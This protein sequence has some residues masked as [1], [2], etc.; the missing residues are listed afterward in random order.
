MCS[1][2]LVALSQTQ[3]HE[4]VHAMIFA[5][6]NISTEVTIN[7][8]PITWLTTGKMGYVAY[9]S[10]ESANKCNEFCRAQNNMA[11]LVDYNVAALI[12]GCFFFGLII[13]LVILMLNEE[14]RRVIIVHER[15]EQ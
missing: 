1:F 3:A 7:Y 4:S 6:Y 2:Y 5:D 8:N 11:E 12:G 9:N 13:L 15:V 14:N 10:V